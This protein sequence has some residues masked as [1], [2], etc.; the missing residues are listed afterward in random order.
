MLRSRARVD[1]IGQIADTS[2]AQSIIHPNPS[3]TAQ[4]FRRFE[5]GDTL[6]LAVKKIKQRFLCVKAGEKLEEFDRLYFL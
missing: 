2:A 1:L 3:E 5:G 6:K 4:S